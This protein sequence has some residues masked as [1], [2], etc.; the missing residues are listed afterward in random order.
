MSEEPKRGR[1]RPPGSKNKSKVERVRS[2]RI[3]N[4]KRE[5]KKR[6][7][8]RPPA[9]P[10]PAAPREVQAEIVLPGEEFGARPRHVEELP[11][12]PEGEQMTFTWPRP[13]GRPEGSTILKPTESI[14]DRIW[15]VGWEQGTQGILA[16]ALGVSATTLRSFM[17]TY[18][19]AK[20][21]YEDARAAGRGGLSMRLYRE[22]QT[23][24]TSALIHASKHWL[25]MSDRFAVPPP[26][27]GEETAEEPRKLKHIVIELVD[28][29]DQAS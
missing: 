3:E 5:A 29:K 28:A 16:V 4:R 17:D 11:Q 21:T 14:L 6:A 26:D 12:P 22:A 24:N 1:G 9:P 27:G 23:G 25:G 7:K 13:R 10:R 19:E 15:Q 8:D 20:A 2:T 18:P